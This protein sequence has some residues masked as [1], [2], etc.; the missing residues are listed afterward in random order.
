MANENIALAILQAAIALA[1]LVLIYS[2]FI[3]TKAAGFQD[4][5]KSRKFTRLAKLALIPTV[6]S[7]ICA[8]VG[9]R[10]LMPGHFGNEWAL[11][12]LLGVFETVLALSAVYAIIA[13][14]YGT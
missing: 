7:L 4:V 5:R 3:L 11:R 8:L 2:G 10:A 6:A 14:F 9:C 13:A 1:G 12:W